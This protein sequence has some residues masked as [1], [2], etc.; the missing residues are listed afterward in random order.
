MHVHNVRV[1]HAQFT[2][3]CHTSHCPHT[4]H[5]QVLALAKEIAAAE[6]EATGDG[7]DVSTEGIR[8]P[9]KTGWGWIKVRIKTRLS[10]R[11]TR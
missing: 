11:W 4:P 5:V 3:T 6:E 7:D 8:E 1:N 10:K 2:P 9:V